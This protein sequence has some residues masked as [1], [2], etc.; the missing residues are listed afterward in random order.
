MLALN[1]TDTTIIGTLSYGLAVLRKDAVLK[2]C[3]RPFPNVAS[4]IGNP[5]IAVGKAARRMAFRVGRAA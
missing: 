2:T 3:F 5:E 1:G 4:H